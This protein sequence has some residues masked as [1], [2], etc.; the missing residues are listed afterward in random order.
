MKRD[1]DYLTR[2]VKNIVDAI[3][4][5]FSKQTEK[6]ADEILQEV[7]QSYMN[8]FGLDFRTIQSL[9]HVSL[10]AIFNDLSKIKLLS[11]VLHEHALLYRSVGNVVASQ[12]CEQKSKILIDSTLER[13]KV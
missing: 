12:A 3:A 1:N 7:N 5:L 8:F 11:Q 6:T 13:E 9:D 4:L 10:K 2:Q